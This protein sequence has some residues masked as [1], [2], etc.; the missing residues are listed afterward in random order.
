M[1]AD[2]YRHEF[3][4]TLPTPSA[5][6]PVPAVERIPRTFDGCTWYA[7]AP[8]TDGEKIGATARTRRDVLARFS[9][10]WAMFA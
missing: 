1:S 9:E 2:L 10:K 3:G 5:P 6:E 7:H 8:A 4:A